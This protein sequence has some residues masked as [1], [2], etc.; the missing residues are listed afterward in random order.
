M[1]GKK[2]ETKIIRAVLDLKREIWK[3]KKISL[4]SFKQTFSLSDD[5]KENLCFK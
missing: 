4:V 1:G 5:D 2:Q 3:I